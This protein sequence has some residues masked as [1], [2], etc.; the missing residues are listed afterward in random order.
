MSDSSSTAPLPPG[1]ALRADLRPGDLGSVVRLH[2]TVYARE[3]GF[4][5]TFE[6]YVAAPLAEFV[7][8]AS[9]RQRLWLAERGEE[10]VGCVSVVAAG[11]Q[12]AQLRWF[13]VEPSARGAGLGK[14]LLTDALAFARAAGYRSVLLWT[15]RSLAAA[16]HLYRSAGFLIAEERP[17]RRWGVDVVEQRY[18]LA[19][20]SPEQEP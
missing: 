4:D 12:E 8:A 17:T 10:F 19:L 2:G 3:C 6:A 7:L 13:L 11:P 15:V 20:Q 9:P 1:I 14:A 5:A 18:E 16:A